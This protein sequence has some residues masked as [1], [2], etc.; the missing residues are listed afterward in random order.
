MLFEIY[1]FLLYLTTNFA[2]QLN[3]Y[4]SVGQFRDE[5]LVN[6]GYFQTYFTNEEYHAIIPG[7]IDFPDQKLIEQ[8][9]Y[10]SNEELRNTDVY[11][12]L[13][14]CENSQTLKAQLIDP[15]LFLIKYSSLRYM[16]VKREQIEFSK[17]PLM[18]GMILSVRLENETITKTNITYLTR[19]L[20]WT[21]RYEV[22]INDDQSA[23]LRALADIN[24]E[25]ERSYNITSSQL[26]TGSVPIASASHRVPTSI[27]TQ[28][29]E[30]LASPMMD[31]SSSI[32][33]KPDS[34]NFGTYSY[35]ITRQFHLRPK[36]IKTF[37]FLTTT[38]KF[39]YTLETTT[40]L[41]TGTTYGLFQRVFIIQPSE[42][43]PAGT[44][45]F[46]LASTG[47]TLGQGRLIDTPKQSE[48]KINLGNDPDVK[49]HIIS[50]IT[51]VRQTPIYG[52][53]LSV[54][55]TIS[56]PKD[57]QIVSV[58]LNI[59]SGYRN[60][61]LIRRNQSSSNITI[62]QD[63][64]NKALLIIRAMIQPNEDETC[65]FAVIQSN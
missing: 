32:S 14:Q 52:Q 17:D 49:F 48:Q 40:Y 18:D 56:N 57:N 25:H 23:V 55:V 37:P 50:I 5:I 10:N 53:D 61:T 4:T 43:L 7:T 1:F 15:Y 47:I 12:H 29:I 26:I 13:N 39:N 38:I 19:G 60:T 24:N 16:Y 28:R 54:N 44:I 20:S 64:N 9:L 34:T 65:M 45:T 63:L 8:D 11:I 62:D 27:D 6:N 31:T 2:L 30:Y 59:N 22:I 33:S 42:F 41:S 36:S 58:T 46:Y 3:F 51:A 21:P 35:N